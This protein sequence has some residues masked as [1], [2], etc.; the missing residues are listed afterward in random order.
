MATFGIAHYYTACNIS[1]VFNNFHADAQ[2]AFAQCYFNII[3][4]E[5]DF[6]LILSVFISVYLVYFR[7]ILEPKLNGNK[8]DCPGN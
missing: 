8:T 4:I 2:Y 6:T 3:N 7:T 5:L 1:A